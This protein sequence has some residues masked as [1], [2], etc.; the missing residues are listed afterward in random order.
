MSD[1]H[2]HY[3]DVAGECSLQ[4]DPHEVIR[5][6]QPPLPC[7]VARIRPARTDDG[8]H[9]PA[10]AHDVVQMPAKVLSQRNRIHIFEYPRPAELG[11][12]TIVN[13]ARGIW[14]ITATIA[15]EDAR[16]G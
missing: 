11:Y 15:D 9:H 12:E 3:R 10:V 4:F 6:L 14:V 13:A 16:Q 7:L 8:E 1:Q 2:G 5:I